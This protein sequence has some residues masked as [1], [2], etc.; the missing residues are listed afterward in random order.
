LKDI[1]QYPNIQTFQLMTKEKLI[2]LKE[3]AKISG[4]SPDYIGQ[5]IRSGKIPGKQVYVNIAWMTTA[6]AVLAY[7]QQKKEKR[8]L[9]FREKLKNES[10]R[11]TLELSIV[12]L[13]FQNFKAAL[14]TLI[15]V[16]IS[17]VLLCFYLL[18]LLFY[19]PQETINAP[20]L[21]KPPIVQY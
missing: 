8:Q 17:F 15:I 4:Y 3:A 21:K 18:Y 1:F 10:R 20:S 14:P 9:T 13:F 16:I 6:E 19:P 5:L 7:K 12:K 11:L 2:T